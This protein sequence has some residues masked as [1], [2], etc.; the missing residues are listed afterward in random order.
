MKSNY[1][2]IKNKLEVGYNFKIS[3]FK[4]QIK[5]TLPHKHE[6]YY[7]LI[8]LNEGEGFHSI[9][10]ERFMVSAP[11]FYLLKPGQL[12]FWQFTS[13]PK[14]FVILL[15][16]SEFNN[17]N[18]VILINSLKK[19]NDTKRLNI[20]KDKYP[21]C[22]LENILIEYQLNTNYSKEIIHGY[23]SAL[24]SKLL[25]IKEERQTDLFI[26]HTLY[27]R[28]V[29]LLVKECPKLHKVNE[30]ADL[31]HT[32]PQNLN[33]I[34]K[35]QTGKSAGKI[36]TNQILTEAKRYILYSENNINEIAEILAFTDASNFIK[37]FK[38]YEN[39]TPTQFRTK[40][41]Q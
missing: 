17:I 34:C 26:Y 18:E 21:F 10:S 6:E 32:T 9:E 3:K 12:H 38:K 22:I 41:F 20:P 40:F 36:I 8:F 2:D 37:F 39:M 30:F 27:D 25:Q 28:F 31:L 13:I 4:E 15:K 24:F 35:K 23:L 1:I 11:E 16:H 14:G 29:E 7:E 19:L 33:I 5:R